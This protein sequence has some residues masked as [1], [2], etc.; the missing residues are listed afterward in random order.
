MVTMR[1]ECPDCGDYIKG[2]HKC[3]ESGIVYNADSDKKE[4]VKK[5]M[6]LKDSSS[7]LKEKLERIIKNQ[8]YS[9]NKFECDE[10]YSSAISIAKIFVSKASAETKARITK[11]RI[12]SLMDENS[13]ISRMFNN[14]TKGA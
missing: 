8:I 5:D 11:E 9:I 7:D 10:R 2:V 6:R 3:W 14:I 13:E 12:L 1:R 4:I